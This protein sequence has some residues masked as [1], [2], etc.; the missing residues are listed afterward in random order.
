MSDNDCAEAGITFPKHA[1]KWFFRLACRVLKQWRELS[2]LGE[3][4]NANDEFYAVFVLF[5]VN[6]CESG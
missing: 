4:E 2:L 5:E 1:Q 3:S 6:L